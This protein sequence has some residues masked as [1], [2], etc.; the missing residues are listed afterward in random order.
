M[1]FIK[2]SDEVYYTD[3]PILTV[4][5]S[6]IQ[7]LKDRAREN[8]RRR[9][10]LC[11]HPDVNDTLHEMLIVHANS[12]YVQPHKHLGKSESF[13][14]IEGRLCIV[15]FDDNGNAT[16][17]IPMAEAGSGQAFYYRLSE[18]RFHTVVPLSDWVVFHEVTNGPFDRTETVFAPWA[19]ADDDDDTAQQ[20]F[21]KTL[22]SEGHA[23]G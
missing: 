23:D 21:L 11:A 4:E 14:I 9:V 16:G 8:P 5:G 2:E 18:S 20:V 19:P 7:F 17:E 6:D 13:H 10:R 22:L 12:N 1:A 15:L 3:G